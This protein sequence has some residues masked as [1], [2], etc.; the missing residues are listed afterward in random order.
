M[1]L[2]A[3]LDNGAPVPT[4]PEGPPEYLDGRVTVSD[5]ELAAMIVWLQKEIPDFPKKLEYNTAKHLVVGLLRALNVKR[6]GY[7]EGSVAVHTD[8]RLARRYYS[9]AEKRLTWLVIQPPSDAPLEVDSGKELPGFSW[10]VHPVEWA[11]TQ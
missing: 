10:T 11:V 8:G 2:N 9:A 1:N 6:L 5:T 7:A 3:T 4:P